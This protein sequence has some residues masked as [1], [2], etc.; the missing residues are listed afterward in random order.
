MKVFTYMDTCNTPNHRNSILSPAT[1]AVRV[2]GNFHEFPWA[3][4]ISVTFESIEVWHT[5]LI[6]HIW[7]KMDIQKVKADQLTWYEGQG[8]ACHT[9]LISIYMEENGHWEGQG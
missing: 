7:K 9:P 1:F 2:D 3:R 6:Y 5:P 8:C 4:D